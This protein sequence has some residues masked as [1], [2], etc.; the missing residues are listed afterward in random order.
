MI[1]KYVVG[2][3]HYCVHFLQI[4]LDHPFRDDSSGVP[5]SA[6]IH[7]IFLSLQPVLYCSY[8]TRVFNNSSLGPKFLNSYLFG[9]FSVM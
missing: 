1:L 5:A 6:N 9:H 2:F 8:K 4:C 3:S 7:K